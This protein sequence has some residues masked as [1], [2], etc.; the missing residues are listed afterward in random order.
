MGSG[1]VPLRPAWDVSHG[2]LQRPD[3]GRALPVSPWAARVV[4]RP[5]W[6]LWRCRAGAQ[7]A[8]TELTTCPQRQWR[9]WQCGRAREKPG[10]ASS[11]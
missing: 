9:S 1:A 11:Q 7:V 3:C 6:L 8:L 10:T 5:A 2:L 4:P